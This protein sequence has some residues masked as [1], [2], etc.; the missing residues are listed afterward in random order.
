VHKDNV[1]RIIP[2]LGLPC[3]L[4]QPDSAFSQGVIK[5]ENEA[6]LQQEVSRLLDKTDMMI[7]QEFIS[8]P[9]DWRIGILDKRPLY[10]CK[11]FMARRHWQ[12]INRNGE[13]ESNFGRV[14]TM[15]V[16]LAPRQV[17]RTALKA[18][19]LI[20]DGFYGVDLK[21]VGRQCYVIEVNDNPS[22]DAGFEDTVLKDEI[23]LRIMEVFL[24]RIE[25]SKFAWARS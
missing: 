1:D 23:Y 22:I 13:G 16:E 15:P 9:F 12:I 24:R 19:N 7:A 17:V 10:A 25:Q 3:V 2:E 14:E 11:Y 20:G 6:M 21:Q 8:T 5:V 18:A 4:K